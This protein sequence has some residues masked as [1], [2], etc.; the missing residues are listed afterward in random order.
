[1]LLAR[2]MHHAHGQGI[3]HRDLKP[4]NVLLAASDRPQAV[5]LG[6]D[7]EM[8]RLYEPRITDF[9]LAKLA[10]GGGQSPAHTG[11]VMGTPSYMAPEQAT[12]KAK[13]AG[14]ATDVY[15]LG[16]ILYE[17][18]TGRP[19][20]KGETPLE[21]LHQVVSEDP[22]PPRRLNAKVPRDLE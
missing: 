11:D 17:L 20:F 8:A 9:G 1:E 12:G 14:P 21:T 6:S 4:S 13:E 7:P 3:I 2:A 19:P 10:V 16:A 18:L 22:V 5:R 15:A